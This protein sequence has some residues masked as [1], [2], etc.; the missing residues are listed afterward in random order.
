MAASPL[1][2]SNHYWR[3][4]VFPSFCGEDVR[5]NFLSHL[6]KSLQ[7]KGISSFKDHG[8]RRSRS[9]WPE[10]KLAIW[11]SKIFIVLLSSNYAGSSWCLNELV[12]IMD[13]K[14]AVGQTLL[15]VFY[16]VDPSD[17]RKQTGAFGNVFEKTCLGRTVKEIQRWKQALT[18]VANVSG[19]CSQKWLVLKLFLIC[20]FSYP[21]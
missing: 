5:R 11:E 1:S 21:L 16:Q 12:E 8:I 10:L 9:I 7:G 19:Y 14:E 6:Q 3:Y 4:H 18:D 15:T 20:E 13:C 2:S 17:V